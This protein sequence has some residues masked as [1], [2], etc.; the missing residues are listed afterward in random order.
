M[1]HIQFLF[2]YLLILLTSNQGDVE[3]EEALPSFHYFHQIV[4]HLGWECGW[5]NNPIYSAIFMVGW[6]WVKVV[7]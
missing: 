7:V 4:I 2:I 5:V 3:K 6:D 1:I